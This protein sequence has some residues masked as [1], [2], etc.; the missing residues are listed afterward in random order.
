M[1]RF[2]DAFTPRIQIIGYLAA[3]L[4]RGIFI[5]FWNKPIPSGF[6]LMGVV[7]FS[8][9]FAAIGGIA[10]A[11]RLPI[12]KKTA[13]IHALAALAAFN[14]NATSLA[15]GVVAVLTVPAYYYMALRHGRV[16]VLKS[17]LLHGGMY[18]IFLILQGAGVLFAQSGWVLLSISTSI[19][20]L[21]VIA[22][23][24][25][26]SSFFGI[27]YKLYLLPALSNAVVCFIYTPF[28]LSSFTFA[29]TLAGVSAASS[30]LIGRTMRFLWYL[31]EK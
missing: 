31:G 30:L 21:M 28:G 26:S 6:V 14:L 25:I 16:F 19:S 29:A 24:F 4:L 17:L 8:I 18:L 3:A 7:A 12:L 20:S 5:Y 13:A 11:P 15:V 9:I 27:R 2:L 23:I 1:Q 10:A 22:I